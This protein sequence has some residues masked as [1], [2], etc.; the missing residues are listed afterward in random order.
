V[1]VGR[2]VKGGSRVGWVN[3]VRTIVGIWGFRHT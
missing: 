1:L 3:D 2:A